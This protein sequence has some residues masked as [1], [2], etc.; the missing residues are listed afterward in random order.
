[1]YRT[2]GTSNKAASL[3]A[4][5][6]C[7][8]MLFIVVTAGVVMAQAPA[9]TAESR[10]ANLVKG[11]AVADANAKESITKALEELGKPAVQEL[12]KTLESKDDE[13][14]RGEAAIVLG[15]LRQK[16]FKEKD[17]ATNIA[18]E[19]ILVR[20]L[21]DRSDLVVYRAGS[22]LQ[23]SQPPSRK[24]ISAYVANLLDDERTL[25]AQGS[26]TIGLIDLGPEATEIIPVLLDCLKN[27][28]RRKDRDLSAGGSKQ[29]LRGERA[30]LLLMLGAVGPKDSRA[31]AALKSAV[32]DEN[33]EDHVRQAALRVIA[34]K[35]DQGQAFLPNLLS[36]LKHTEN[37][38]AESYPGSWR[39]D[40]MR[41]LG[42]LRI[43]KKEV[44]AI[45]RIAADRSETHATRV[46]ALDV[47]GGAVPESEF[48]WKELTEILKTQVMH[49][50]VMKGIV[51]TLGKIGPAAK[52]AK[53]TLE[54]LADE[55]KFDPRLRQAIMDTLKKIQTP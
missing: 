39:F 6:Y 25:M 2:F 50:S 46:A 38:K 54:N 23:Q 31:L 36:V 22:A 32:D 43:T 27:K 11:L 19:A 12:L 16:A 44:P 34:E 42:R 48:A 24:A 9:P 15:R 37:R 53:P 13:K 4:A 5:T 26:A 33:E 21:R 10:A 28:T 51:E 52:E 30:G 14:L 55:T 18:I 35:T 8:G 29:C 40:T 1:M 7:A 3:A 17:Q 41:Q 47:I 20:F 45:L 49:P